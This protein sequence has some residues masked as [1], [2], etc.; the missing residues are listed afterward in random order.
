MRIRRILY[1]RRPSPLMLVTVAVPQAVQTSCAAFTVRIGSKLSSPQADASGAT[2]GSLLGAASRRFC[3]TKAS[4]SLG[5]WRIALALSTILLAMLALA[6]RADAFV[7]W[8][9]AN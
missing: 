9:N 2:E 3:L 1:Q 7:Y 5:T 6:A 4:V 8:T